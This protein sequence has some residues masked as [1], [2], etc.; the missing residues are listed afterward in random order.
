[1]DRKNVRMHQ[2]SGFIKN[3]KNSDGVPLGGAMPISIRMNFESSI[4]LHELSD[5]IEIFD[6]IFRHSLIFFLENPQKF[7][8]FVVEKDKKI[9]STQFKIKEVPKEIDF[10]FRRDVYLS[11]IKLRG[12]S[13]LMDLIPFINQGAMRILENVTIPMIAGLMKDFATQKI[14]ELII[15]QIWVDSLLWLHYIKNSYAANSE[16]INKAPDA[17]M[18]NIAVLQE[19]G[20]LRRVTNNF[21]RLS[22]NYTIQTR[23]EK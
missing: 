5:F 18:N 20:N 4:P 11:A 23:F 2:K 17:S 21:Y 7:V 16:L 19:C 9:T 1:M 22:I 13:W 14:V 6:E 12:G 8:F 15:Q 10:I 3:T